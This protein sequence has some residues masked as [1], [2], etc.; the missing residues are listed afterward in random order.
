MISE[1]D[2]VVGSSPRHQRRAWPQ[3]L[4]RLRLL[5]LVSVVAIGFTARAVF[6]SSATHPLQ[7][8]G[9]AAEQ[10]EIAR[11]IVD[12]GRWFVVNPQAFDLLKAQQAKRHALVD[13]ADIDFARVDRTT[14]ATPEVDQMPGVAVLLAGL[15]A[16][17]GTKTYASLQWLQIVLDTLLV[18]VVYWIAR[19]LTR[20]ESVALLAGALYAVW[21]GAIVMDS[22]PMLDTWAAFF[23]IA[24]LAVFV[25][26]R[27]RTAT[28]RRL[29]PLGIVAGIG[30]Y[31]RPFIMFM[32]LVLAFAA[33]PGGWRERLRWAVVPTVVALLVLAPWTARNYV[34]FHRFI[35]TRTGLGQAVFEGSGQAA[36]D[37]GA[38]SYV[39]QHGKAAQYGSPAY[40]DFLLGGALKAIEADPVTYLRKVAWR[41]R[42]LLPCLLILLVWRRWQFGARLLVGAAAA[43]IL[44]YLLVG[45]D[46]RYYLPV[47][48]AYLI[49]L[50]MAVSIGAARFLTSRRH[51]S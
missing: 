27:E 33:A 40:D 47:A 42:Y 19:K 12:H 13:P 4:Q 29:V 3:E 7:G 21:P 20:K 25:W 1:R 50:A 28:V 23:T 31:F 8:A 6:F 37:T 10:G 5:A 38:K 48:P 43:V 39:H 9:L 35:A 22:R 26:T 18:L 51:A 41:S 34:E 49:L 2:Q 14:K 16:I 11:N 45:D 36:T 15:W 30:I 32:P 46:T 44:P 24:C 17:T